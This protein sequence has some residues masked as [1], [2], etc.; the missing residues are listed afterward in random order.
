MMHNRSVGLWQSW[1]H[2]LQD[3]VKGVQGPTR[4]ARDVRL[5]CASSRP[6]VAGSRAAEPAAAHTD[7][8]YACAAQG[9]LGGTGVDGGG[10][11]KNERGSGP[12]RCC[13][14]A[15]RLLFLMDL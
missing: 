12:K 10:S 13:L 5:L 8:L 15:V 6:R 9:G 4:E 3:S 7:S 11:A 14:A 2:C 1:R